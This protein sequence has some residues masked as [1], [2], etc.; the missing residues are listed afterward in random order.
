MRMGDE[1]HI[2]Q[3]FAFLDDFCLKTQEGRSIFNVEPIRSLIDG[4]YITDAQ[5]VTLAV[6][7]AYERI[8]GLNR[9][10]LIGRYMGDLVKLGYLSNSVSLEVIKR[11]DVVTLVQTIHGHQKILVTGSPIF[12]QEQRLVCIVTCVR[13]ITELLRAKHAQEQLEDLF[14]SQEQYK[15]DPCVKDFIMSKHTQPIFDLATQVAKFDS[16]VMIG[17]ETGTGKSQLARYIH[18]MSPRREQAFLALNC[19]GMPDNLL[20]IELF[21]Y[22]AGAFTGALPKGKK[23]LLEI[24]HQGSLFLDEIADLPLHMQIKLLKV[25]EE[26]RFLPVGGT[27]FKQ[28]DVRI[29]SATHRDLKDTVAQGKFREDLFY[30]LNVVSF[31]LPPLRER[32]V[33]IIPLLEHYLLLWNQKYQQHKYFV[34]EV[35]EALSHYA[36]PG[37]IRELVNMVERLCVTTPHDQVMLKD[38]PVYMQ[39]YAHPKAM[40]L[41]EHVLAYERQLIVEALAQYGST[42]ATADALGVE[43]S[44]LV[45]KIAR[46][47]A[48]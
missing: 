30:R 18:Q 7:R 37:N 39:E 16:K 38:L 2:A 13:D 26:Q 48:H 5:A 44:T 32:R 9:S 33:E 17:G 28:V 47:K 10:A 25:I 6:N 40:T 14:R 42:R 22:E 23:G 45:K 1:M 19:A 20:E 3:D 36:W 29:I 4:I 27:E 11:Q 35:F 34:P 43:Q 15:V 24:A 41:K 12:D 8:T 21:G 46:F 31:E